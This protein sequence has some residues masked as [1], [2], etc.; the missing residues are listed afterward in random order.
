MLGRSTGVKERAESGRVLAV[1]LAQDR[2]FRKQ[3]LAAISHSAA[4]KTRARK[5]TGPMATAKRLAADTRLRFE[6]RGWTPEGGR[7]KIFCARCGSALFSC[8]P[9]SGIYT[10]VRLG[11]IDGDPGIRPR[12]RAFVAYAAPW[13]A[14]PDDGLPRFD[15]ARHGYDEGR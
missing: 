15:E 1:K 7:E 8:E 5:K 9:R 6:L 4:A 3:L 13:E 2:K 14:I 11:A 12:S 10:G